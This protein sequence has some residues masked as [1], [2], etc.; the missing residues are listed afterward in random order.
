MKK[1]LLVQLIFISVFSFIACSNGTTTGLVDKS[2]IWLIVHAYPSISAVDGTST[3]YSVYCQLQDQS[4]A[5]GMGDFSGVSINI[6]GYTFTDTSGSNYWA[7][8]NNISLSMGDSL[9]VNVSHP[10]FGSVEATG[11]VPP[12]LATFSLD[13]AFPSPNTNSSYDLSWTPISGVDEYSPS[14]FAYE[15]AARTDFIEGIGYYTTGSPYTLNVSDGSP[16][17][18][19]EFSV[20]TIDET[21]FLEFANSSTLEIEGTYIYEITN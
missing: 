16:Y 6:N 10:S 7:S 17:P 5:D 18:Y 15:D 21:L 2:N 14:Y 13:K 8:Y 1:I 3:N 19:L 20:S 9:L 4:A 12:S 11:V